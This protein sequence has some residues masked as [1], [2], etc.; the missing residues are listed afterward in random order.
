MKDKGIERN[1][2]KRKKE[3][4]LYL[5]WLRQDAKYIYKYIYIVK[6]KNIY[7]YI[8]YI[9]NILNIKLY[10]IIIINKR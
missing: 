9:Y 1:R 10:I 2:I 4:R 6:K 7:I 3:K 5:T 8:K